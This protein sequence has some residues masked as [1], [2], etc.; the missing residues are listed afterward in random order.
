MTVVRSSRRSYMNN[1][2]DLRSG[3]IPTWCPGC[4]DYVIYA[5]LQQAILELNIPK[6]NVVMVY[7][8][9]C[10]GNIADLFSVY[11]IHSLHGRCIPTALGVKMANPKL[12][13]IALGGDGGIYGEGLNHLLAAARLN[14]DIAVIVANNHIYSL[15][16]GQTS[17]TTPKGYKTKSTPSGAPSIAVDPIP[18]LNV[19][20]QE[21]FA[22]HLSCQNPVEVTT[23]IKEAITHPGFALLDL[24]QVCVTFGKKI[25]P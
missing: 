13:V 20:N 9:G 12:T 4:Q 16:T 19:V 14:L 11:S 6:E 18:L 8:I 15:T 3:I 24:D 1:L 7:D 22:K 17:P 2:N 25:S 21:I 10:I 23:A 5:G